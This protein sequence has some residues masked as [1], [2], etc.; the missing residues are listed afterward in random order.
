MEHYSDDLNKLLRFPIADKII[1]ICAIAVSGIF[2]LWIDKGMI[3]AVGFKA[4]YG[5]LL[6][7]VDMELHSA[8]IAFKID[9]IF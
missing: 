4:L 5:H 1:S 8:H 7:E 3:L 6:H 9:Y 2:A